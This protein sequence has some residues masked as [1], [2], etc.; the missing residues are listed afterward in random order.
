MDVF[1]K[2]NS[3]SDVCCYIALDVME[4]TKDFIILEFPNTPSAGTYS[5]NGVVAMLPGYVVFG[6]KVEFYREEKILALDFLKESY[7]LTK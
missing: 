3:I 5:I 2:S 1:L 7:H 4:V 6:V